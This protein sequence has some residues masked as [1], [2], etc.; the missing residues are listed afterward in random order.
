MVGVNYEINS[1]NE[2]Q[3]LIGKVQHIGKKTNNVKQMI[4]FQF[5]IGKVQQYLNNLD[6]NTQKVSIPHR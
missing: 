6:F 2:F 3:F 5:L 4:L 1:G